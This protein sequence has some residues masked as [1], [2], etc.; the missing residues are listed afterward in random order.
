MNGHHEPPLATVVVGAGPAGLLFCITARLLHAAQGGCATEWPIYLF[1][2]RAGYERTHRLRIAP[3]PF[4]AIQAAV[5]DP[6]FDDLIAFLDRCHFS[7]AVNDL[8]HQLDALARR[9]G[10]VKELVAVGPGAGE[11]PVTALPAFLVRSGR[12][13]PATQLTIVGADS[14]HS[15]V[16]DAV[17]GGTRVVEH[18]HQTVARLRVTGAQLP[19][20]LGRLDRYRLSKVLGSVVDYRRNPNGFA[21]VDV[22]LDGD[23]HERVAALGATP[24]SPIEL[25]PEV[26][27]TLRA[28]LLDRLVGHLRRGLGGAACCVE[29]QSTFR[30]EH[31][32]LERLVHPLPPAAPPAPAR[33]A[34]GTTVLLVGDAAIS[35]PFFRGMACMAAC[36][37]SLARAHLALLAGDEAAP[38]RYDDEAAAIRRAELAVVKARA[39]LVRGACEFARVSALV[40]FPLQTWLLSLP[41]D[42][43]RKGR[44]TAGAALNV[45]V[46]AVALLLATAGGARW[47][48]ALGVEVVGGF[49]YRAT[50]E[51]EGDNGLVHQVWR[52]QIAAL[53][54]GGVAWA[55][56]DTAR[57]GHPTSAIAALTWFMCGIAFVVGLEAFDA[58]S[59]R[60]FAQARLG[61]SGELR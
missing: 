57:A 28:P 33:T 4:R 27:R 40:P 60:W 23:A 13:T 61:P 43:R 25:T 56:L 34:R 1:D 8:E 41:A 24:A 7:P 51:L 16:S 29:L 19:E 39:R 36:V 47:W 48:A 30:L 52:V 54:V 26:T 37:L 50:A 5:A 22:F 15:T 9:V 58:I 59:R 20:H 6:G 46:A 31:R 45:L 32:Y 17:R 2:K 38:A 18:I 55:A 21:E 11:V 44:L 3:E 42:D 49:L 53:L 14:V 35:L 10:V 12:L